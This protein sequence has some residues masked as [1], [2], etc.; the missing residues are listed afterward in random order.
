MARR[1]AYVT[2]LTRAS[3][4]PGVLV[5]DHTLRSVDSAF[6]LIVMA[7]PTLPQNARGVLERRGISIRPIRSLNPQEGV[8]SLSPQDARFADTWTKLRCVCKPVK[9]MDNS[10]LD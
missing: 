5:L 3:Y 6:P 4:L 7:T 8:H 9:L 2:L 10:F 1:V